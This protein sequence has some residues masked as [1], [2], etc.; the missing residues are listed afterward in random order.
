MLAMDPSPPLRLLQAVRRAHP[1]PAGSIDPLRPPSRI[2]SVFRSVV[3]IAS[4]DGLLAL[5][6][7]AVGGLPHGVSVRGLDARA[8]GLVPGMRV[9]VSASDWSIP[10][11]GVRVVL[12]GAQRWSPGLSSVGPHDWPARRRHVT[13]HLHR[14]GEGSTSLSAMVRAAAQT[15]MAELSGAISAGDRV[16]AA[17]VAR[18][19][20]G[21]GPGSTPAG[22][23]VLTGAE[24][25]LR[26]TG[27]P[28]AGFTGAALVDVEMRTTEVAA[29]ML[30]HAARG[31]FAERVHRLVRAALV[32]DLPA[33]GDPLGGA[34]AWGA[35]SGQDTLVG[36]VLAMDATSHRTRRRVA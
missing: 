20:I 21:L 4:P 19:L 24:A 30:R 13:A 18:H 34:A 12:H 36:I 28:L 14:I 3:D 16:A 32:D 2:S 29:A 17:S 10:D 5:A 35:T 25:G 27:H 15:A 1:L 6:D 33:V 8:L 9:V 31:A 7:D 26:A 11:A 22:D 23:D